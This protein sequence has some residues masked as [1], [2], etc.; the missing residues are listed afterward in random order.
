MTAD[1]AD[2]PGRITREDLDSTLRSVVG[3]V[4][5]QAN[6]SARRSLPVAIGIGLGLLAAAYFLGRRVGATTSTVVE[7]RRI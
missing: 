4:E 6:H 3:E 1:R 2:E 5:Q 7:I